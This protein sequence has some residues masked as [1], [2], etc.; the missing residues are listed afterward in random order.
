MHAHREIDNG[1]VAAY[2]L[3]IGGG[4]RGTILS[5]E[6]DNTGQLELFIYLCIYYALGKQITLTAKYLL[7]EYNHEADWQFTRATESMILPNVSL[8][9]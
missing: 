2:A 9:N 3:K 6:R 4:D 7:G 1:T 5:V 8:F